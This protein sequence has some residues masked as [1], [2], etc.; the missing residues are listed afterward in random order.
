[1]KRASLSK[2]KESFSILS[3]Q[4]Q[5]GRKRDGFIIKN[6]KC[7]TRIP[8]LLGGVKEILSVVL[9]PSAKK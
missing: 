6:G 4:D 5:D 9:M 7:F 8:S 1:M 2:Q 3:H